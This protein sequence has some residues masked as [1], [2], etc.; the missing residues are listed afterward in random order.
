MYLKCYTQCLAPPLC[1]NEQQLPALLL[2]EG[3]DTCPVSIMGS[4]DQARWMLGKSARN[5]V[6]HKSEGCLCKDSSPTSK[7]TLIYYTAKIPIFG[8][9]RNVECSLH[10]SCGQNSNQFFIWGPHINWTGNHEPEGENWAAKSRYWLL[11]IISQLRNPQ[12]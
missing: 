5:R 7:P 8:G 6:E 1:P 2:S 4:W 9:G 11:L 12:S 10:S 3:K